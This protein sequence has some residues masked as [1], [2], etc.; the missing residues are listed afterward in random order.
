MGE[1]FYSLRLLQLGMISLIEE[2][3]S[4]LWDIISIRFSSE[5]YVFLGSIRY[6]KNKQHLE[7]TTVYTPK[8]IKNQL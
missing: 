3:F 1:D 4:F 6:L 5:N 7:T 8:H 2:Y